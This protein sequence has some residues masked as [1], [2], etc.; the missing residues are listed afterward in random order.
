MG[1]AWTIWKKK[2]NHMRTKR[3]WVKHNSWQR[4]SCQWKARPGPYGKRV[5]GTHTSDQD[6]VWCLGRMFY[7]TCVHWI[8]HKHIAR[9]LVWETELRLGHLHMAMQPER[10]KR[11]CSLYYH[12]YCSKAC[13][14][15]EKDKVLS[16]YL[17]VHSL[18]A[19]MLKSELP[20]CTHVP[21]ETLI[22]LSG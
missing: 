15:W 20:V 14:L 1:A 7:W 6:S 21:Y 4:L 3:L 19:P 2:K 11:G 9:A 5:D 16:N 10:M 22:W 12:H 18:L 17:Y 13:L 8:C